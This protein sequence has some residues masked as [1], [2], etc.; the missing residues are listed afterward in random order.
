MSGSAPSGEYEDCGAATK[1]ARADEWQP[2]PNL[3]HPPRTQQVGRREIACW[4]DHV[5]RRWPLDFNTWTVTQSEHDLHSIWQCGN[6]LA[7]GF[8]RGGCNLT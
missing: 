2:L 3:R 4:N 7:A 8:R 5:L 6:G 1:P